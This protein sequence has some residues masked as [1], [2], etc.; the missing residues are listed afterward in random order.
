[1]KKV[2][3]FSICPT[4]FLMIGRFKKERDLRKNIKLYSF[5]LLNLDITT[6]KIKFIVI[7]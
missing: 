4:V 1:M 7:K 2:N 6:L 5:Y 3:C